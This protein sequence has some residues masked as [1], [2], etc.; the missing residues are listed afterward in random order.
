MEV[1]IYCLFGEGGW[2]KT[3]V[4]LDIYIYI[5]IIVHGFITRFSWESIIWWETY[6]RFITRIKGTENNAQEYVKIPPCF[7][8]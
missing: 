5:H 2:E 1:C 8:F 6:F 4:L 3:G 7:S